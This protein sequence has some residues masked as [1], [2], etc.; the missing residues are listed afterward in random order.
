LQ[1]ANAQILNIARQEGWYV[2][3]GAGGDINDW[4]IGYNKLLAQFGVGQPM[5][6]YHCNGALFDATFGLQGDD[7]YQPD[8]SFLFFPLNGLDVEK[9]RAFQ[10][11]NPDD[12]FFTTLNFSA[13]Y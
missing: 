13:E 7:A 5:E 2:I 8:I 12:G 3:T 11:E 6:W 4:I 1:E 9:L 10:K